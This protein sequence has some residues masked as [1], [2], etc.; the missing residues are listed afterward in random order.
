[1]LDCHSYIETSSFRAA[2]L[3]NIQVDLY[4]LEQKSTKSQL[5]NIIST[6][7]IAHSWSAFSPQVNSIFLMLDCLSYL[8]ES[9]R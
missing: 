7:S 5:V 6:Q 4:V 2:L 9:P 3:L 1:M 8:M